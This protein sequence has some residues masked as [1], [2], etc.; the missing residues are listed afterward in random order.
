MKKSAVRKVDYYFDIFLQDVKKVSTTEYIKEL[1]RYNKC[2]HDL[3]ENALSVFFAEVFSQHPEFETL[4][5]KHFRKPHD[6]P[7]DIMQHLLNHSAFLKKEDNAW[8]RSVVEI[9]RSTSLYFQPQ[10]R[11]KIMN[12]GWASYWHEILF[13]ADD[14]IKGHEIEFARVNAGVTSL[15][16]IGLNPYALGLRLFNHI[17]ELGDTG[18]YSL[19]YRMLPGIRER[20]DFNTEKHDGRNMIFRVREHLNDFLFI[21]HFIDQEFIDKHKLFVSGKRLNPQRMVWEYYVKSRDA[22]AYKK[23]LHDSLYHPPF[24]TV[25]TDKNKDNTLYLVHHFEGKPLINEFITN[26]LLGIEYLWGSPVKLETSEVVPSP[27][28]KENEGEQAND[29]IKWER[30]VY[31]MKDRKLSRST[32]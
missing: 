29:E 19:D 21:E 17:E 3:G 9:I 1:D 27:P 32:L 20:L 31:T 23:M 28:K 12:E 11:T 5:E 18:R 13:L 30:V 6:A 2:S 15:P 25:D 26:T 22:N 24:V 7:S 8:M 16:R 14:R 10:I 4:M